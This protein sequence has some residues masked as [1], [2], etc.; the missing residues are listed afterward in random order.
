[1]NAGGNRITYMR[2]LLVL[3]SCVGLALFAGAAQNNDQN[4]NNNQFKKK[5]GNAPQ[6]QQVVTQQTGKK[7]KTGAGPHNQNF[8]Q[9][10]GVTNYQQTGKHGKNWQGQA[11]VS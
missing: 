6:Q 1:M 10:T 5:G 11:N 7:F 8:Q 9:P 4:N 2:I 3:T